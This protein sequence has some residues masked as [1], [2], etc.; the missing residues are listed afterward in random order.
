MT[1]SKKRKMVAITARIAEEHD[2]FLATRDSKTGYIREL[3][4][5]DEEFKKWKK[6]QDEK[7]I[8]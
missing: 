6:K 5:N 3:L 2:Q 8:N 7:S 4:D 1:K